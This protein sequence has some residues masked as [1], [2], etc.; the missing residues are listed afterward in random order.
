MSIKLISLTLFTLS[1]S[2][3]LFLVG[4]HKNRQKLYEQHDKLSDDFSGKL[5]SA[6][7]TSNTAFSEVDF[8]IESPQYNLNWSH[9]DIP[10]LKITFH[11]KLEEVSICKFD[12]E[13]KSFWEHLTEVLAEENDNTK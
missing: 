11:V 8:S 13:V 9:G 12:F 3:K 6:L 5:S 2:A 4:E 10:D 7:K 1:L